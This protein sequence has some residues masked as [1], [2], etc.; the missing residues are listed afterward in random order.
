MNIP[1][2]PLDQWIDD[3]VH[4]LQT[5]WQPLFDVIRNI[6]QPIVEFFQSFFS[7]LPAFGTIL[8]LSLLT[9]WLTRLR[10]ALFAL[11]GL[12]LIHNLGYW[13]QSIETLSL[14]LTATFLSIVIGIP[15]GLWSAKSNRAYRF[16]RPV[17]DFMQ[18]MPAFVYLI[19]AVFFFSLGTIPGVIASVI[20][21]M[22]PTIRLTSLG[23]RQV[24]KELREVA[25]SFGSTAWQKLWKVEIPI[26][27][28]T[29]FT[30]IN[31]TI[32][33][34]LSMVVVASMIGAGGLGAVVLESISRLQVG[35]GFAA[36]LAIVII[37]ILLDRLTQTLSDTQK[38][39]FYSSWHRWTGIAL[40][41]VI[42]VMAV[43]S[44][45][46][47][48]TQGG[49]K[50]TLAYVNWESEIASTHVV[51]HVLQSQGFTVEMKQVEAGPMWQGVASGSAD[52][53]VA[54]WLPTTH[55]P[56]MEASKGKVENLGPNL[57]GT[58]LGLVV[59]D[60]V[61]IQSIDELSSSADRFGKQIIGIDPGAGIM[62]GTQTAIQKYQLP[63]KLV[64]G[65]DAAMTAAL[66]KAI[67][68][69]EWIVI[70]GW[71]PHWKFSQYKLKFLADP[72]GVYG[73]KES[74][75]TI[76]RKGLKEDKPQAYQILDRFHWTNEDMQ[77][78]ML[79]IHSGKSPDEAAQ[80]W[81]K[82]HPAKVKEWV[83]GKNS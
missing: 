29:I 21:A 26:A 18:T 24:S 75:Y 50:V 43:F 74:I 64:Q 37:A 69:K 66:A 11:L 22:P 4:W 2:I 42:I 81:I 12:L 19:P 38:N 48:G 60:Y 20:F 32:M 53:H 3:L 39:R 62:K 68:K 41:T 13:N 8:L 57:E 52:A 78:V 9:W 35:Q 31:Q 6:I 76:V 80:D 14:V 67:R 5:H 17:L 65:S 49:K 56:Q 54:A 59:P 23:L 45:A 25:D 63:L 70:T 27:K 71:K 58:Q 40:A 30:G 47:M 44:L 77:E 83:S 51:K 61:T 33:L 7:I 34:S 73:Q 16:I 28:P 1:K 15:L 10:F 46:Q 79:Q 36:G 72:K 82:K 55:K